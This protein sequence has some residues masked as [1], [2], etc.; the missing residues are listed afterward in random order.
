M[1]RATFCTHRI[2]PAEITHYGV[3]QVTTFPRTIADVAADGLAD[4]PIIQ[5]VQ[6]AVA[7]GLGTPEQLFAA[8]A[9]RLGDTFYLMAI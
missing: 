2:T 7:R 6:E 8:A 3:L 9:V 5:A 1:I 4:D